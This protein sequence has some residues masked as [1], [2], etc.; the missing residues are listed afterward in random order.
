[1]DLVA[2][3]DF[4]R[5]VVRYGGSHG[6]LESAEQR[7]G[8]EQLPNGENRGG[9][10]ERERAIVVCHGRLTAGGGRRVDSG[11]NGTTCE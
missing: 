2:T 10:R 3:I 1:M 7:E 8:D 9:R 4:D 5:E 11:K 6:V